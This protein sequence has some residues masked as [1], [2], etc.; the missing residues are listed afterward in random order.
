MADKAMRYPRGTINSLDNHADHIDRL[1]AQVDEMT[2]GID[3]ALARLDALADK[4]HEHELQIGRL[5]GRA[6]T[7]QSEPATHGVLSQEELDE[8][9]EPA[10]EPPQAEPP[11]EE[12]EDL[13]PSA[14]APTLTD[15]ALDYAGKIYALTERLDRIEA[16]LRSKADHADFGKEG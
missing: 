3:T 7:G 11:A 16:H 9:L 12:R 6:D 8:I 13:E 5:Q 15:R 2:A 1:N 4:V 10:A 14:E